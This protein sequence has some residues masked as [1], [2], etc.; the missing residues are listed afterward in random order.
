MT[1]NYSI[2]VNLVRII[3]WQVVRAPPDGRCWETKLLIY[4]AMGTDS[5]K[6]LKLG[7]ESY[8]HV[9]KKEKEKEPKNC[10]LVS[11]NCQTPNVLTKEIYLAI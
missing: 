11:S 6:S 7:L 2:E 8:N 9:R 3:T 5:K 10:L 4:G 1:L